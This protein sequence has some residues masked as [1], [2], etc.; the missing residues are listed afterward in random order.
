M[1]IAKIF[2]VPSLPLA[3]VFLSADYPDGPSADAIEAQVQQSL[4]P[5][6]GLTDA[7]SL[8]ERL[9]VYAQEIAQQREVFMSI[10]GHDALGQEA[11]ELPQT[12]LEIHRAFV[13]ACAEGFA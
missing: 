1:T 6:A 10:H 12:H 8:D 11:K 5:L 3:Q 13:K 4:P 2:P 7:H 9:A